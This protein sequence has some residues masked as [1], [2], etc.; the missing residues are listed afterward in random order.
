MPVILAP[1][2]QDEGEFKVV[3]LHHTVQGQPELH[4]TLSQKGNKNILV[5]D[6]DSSLF[7]LSSQIINTLLLIP[8]PFKPRAAKDMQFTA[9]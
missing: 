5:K 8:I 3:L 2:R 6:I 1:S 9:H 4:E 7:W